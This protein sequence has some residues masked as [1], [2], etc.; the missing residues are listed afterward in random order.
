MHYR[1][2]NNS[3]KKKI[4]LQ[5]EAKKRCTALAY[6]VVSEWQTLA[7][8]ENSHWCTGNI[9]KQQRLENGHSAGDFLRQTLKPNVLFHLSVILQEKKPLFPRV[10]SYRHLF[11]FITALCTAPRQISFEPTLI[12]TTVCTCLIPKLKSNGRC[13]ADQ[14]S[15]FHLCT[16]LKECLWWTYVLGSTPHGM[17]T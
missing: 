10:T 4:N 8:L 14:R 17:H 2:W 12:N 7:D 3:F 16:V 5:F 11:N 15:F 1:S 13:G 9:G 6:L